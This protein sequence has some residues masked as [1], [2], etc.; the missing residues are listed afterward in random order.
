MKKVILGLLLLL[1]FASLVSG[2]DQIGYY[3]RLQNGA[4]T[5][6]F[7]L[8]TSLTNSGGAGTLSWPA[9]G[10]TL[11][12][13]TG[14]GTLGS[15]AFT[16]STAY[17]PAFGTLTNT[18]L[19]TTNGTTVSCTTPTSTFQAAG[20]YQTL[21]S[22]LTSLSG[23]TYAAASF[24]KMT[25]ANAF[26][27]DTNTYLTSLT[28]AVLTD[29]TAGQTI[30]ATGARL[31]KL[32]AT[33]ITVTNAIAGGVTGNAGTVTGL[34]VTAG[35]TLT[36]NNTL[37][38]S[39]TD[40]ST[41][42]IGTGGTLGTAAYTAA[43]AYA[44]SS[45]TSTAT[46]WNKWD[47]GS[48][49]LTAATGR[50]SLGLGTMATQAASSV[51]ITGG[52]VRDVTDVRITGTGYGEKVVTYTGQATTTD[53]LWVSFDDASW[54]CA[55]IKVFW[56]IDGSGAGSEGG[57]VIFLVRGASS[58][59]PT[60]DSTVSQGASPSG[61]IGVNVATTKIAKVQLTTPN[62]SGGRIT[63][64]IKVVSTGRNSTSADPTILWQ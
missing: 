48:T 59:T 21:N 24:V 44:P 18:N 40:S 25:G 3:T 33:D 57:E 1:S 45:S 55:V 41:L 5:I 27:L 31:T 42:A 13:P 11:T 4:G 43:T 28:G 15:A 58:L 30:G 64:H 51:A 7:Q 49:G 34:S 20:S 14:G 61:V 22:N 8:N 26:T 6:F 12:I 60:L 37:T 52:T 54:A 16:N 10:A 36:V 38:L 32:W 63:A 50:T 2:A 62:E 17:A 39:G 19:C 53:A 35:K 23:L 9:A 47:G 29:Q 46:D 56:C